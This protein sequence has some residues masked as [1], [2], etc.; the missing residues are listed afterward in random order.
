[1][2]PR[3]AAL[4]GWEQ[5]FRTSERLSAGATTQLAV[6][7]NTLDYLRDPVNFTYAL[8]VPKTG[9]QPLV[10]FLT[11]THVGYCQH[12]A[13]AA[14]LLLRLAGIPTRVATGYATGTW[15]R[16][17]Y[18]VRGSD[19]HAWIEVYFEDYGWV[20]FDATSPA[21]AAQV[22]TAV[23]PTAPPRTQHASHSLSPR[24]IALVIIGFLAV[25]AMVVL[26]KRW[27]ARER[28]TLAELLLRVVP[29]LAAPSTT[30][31][32]ISPDLHRLGPSTAALAAE[33]EHRRFVPGAGGPDLDRHPWW[34]L[35]RALTA[36]VGL[37][38]GTWLLVFGAPPPERRSDG[39][40]A[41]AGASAPSLGD[42]AS[43]APPPQG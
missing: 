5:V 3:D 39:S 7:R 24:D 8:D 22:S 34:R 1:M 16:D 10:T 13:G 37:V 27:R 19:A 25:G 26:V 6:V 38:R 40:V 18:V 20:P 36:D 41:A 23:D 2:L 17:R 32:A 29:G 28:R 14:A 33:V 15:D 30:M 31:R 12:Y 21:A 42:S 11:D 9:P 43:V 35:W 4:S